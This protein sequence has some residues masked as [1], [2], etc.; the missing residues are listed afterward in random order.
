VRKG[1]AEVALGWGGSRR[2]PQRWHRS[3][4]LDLESTEEC[5]ED[6]RPGQSAGVWLEGD[7]QLWT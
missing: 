4:D 5:G 7:K 3:L 2:L 6:F 1:R